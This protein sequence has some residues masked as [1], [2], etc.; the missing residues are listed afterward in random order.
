MGI[1]TTGSVLGTPFGGTE[2]PFRDPDTLV[3]N[4]EGA[5]I[6]IRIGDATVLGQIASVTMRETKRPSQLSREI[7]LFVKTMAGVAFVTAVVFLVLG[8]LRGYSVAVNFS[9]AV[10]IFVAFVPQGLPVT[11][12]AL[13]LTLT[14]PMR[15]PA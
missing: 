2:G 14:W 1:A 9:F 5:G 11:L 4:G 8:F 10:G 6:V 15:P 12:T 13:V 3:V 7:D